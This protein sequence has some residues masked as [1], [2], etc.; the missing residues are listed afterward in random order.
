[1]SKSTARLVRIAD[2]GSI[3]SR[4][5]IAAA[6]LLTAASVTWLGSG[7]ATTTAW[8]QESNRYEQAEQRQIRPL[9]PIPHE[10]AFELTAASSSEQPVPHSDGDSEATQWTTPEQ[11]WETPWTGAEPVLYGCARCPGVCRCPGHPAKPRREMPGDVDRCDCP[12]YRYQIDQRLRSGDPDCVYKWAQP[13]YSQKYTAWYVGG[14]GGFIKGRSR[15]PQEGTWGLDYGGLFGHAKV[16][17]NYT[18]NRYQGGEGAYETEH[19]SLRSR[20]GHHE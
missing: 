4:T 1:M 6:K 8:A 20:F 16:W 10:G 5:G 14:G 15:T 17:L 11:Q 2:L 9:Q 7:I 3:A 18:C 13:T 19:Q 12:P